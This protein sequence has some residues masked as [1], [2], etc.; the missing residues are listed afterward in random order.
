MTVYVLTDALVFPPADGASRE[1]LVAIGGDPSPE[2]LILAYSQGIFP[3]P[4]EDMPLLWFSP[5]PRFVLRPSEVHISRSLAK[6]IRSAPFTVTADRAFKDVM[7]ACA[8]VPRP[9]QDGTWIT[10]DIKIGYG[11][12]HELGFAHS[13]EVWQGTELVGGLYGVSLGAAFF[14]ESMFALE[15]DASKIA[16]VTLAGNL[17]QWGFAFID[18]QVYTRHLEAMGAKALSRKRFLGEVRSALSHPTR[19]GPW[20]LNLDPG[21]AV[22]ALLAARPKQS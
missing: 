21:E 12:L 19:K 1:G 13:I 11:K 7:T 6:R 17:H 2:R 10:D 22:M 15:R 20:A 5:N 9:S 16:F 14:G 4:H 3:W 8:S 18:C